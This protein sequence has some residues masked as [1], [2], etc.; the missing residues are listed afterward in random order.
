MAS[1]HFLLGLRKCN[2][3][4][5]RLTCACSHGAVYSHWVYLDSAHYQKTQRK[6]LLSASQSLQQ[7]L[8]SL[9]EH[10]A[11]GS[12][13][14]SRGVLYVSDD[15]YSFR[16]HQQC[17]ASPL[18]SYVLMLIPVLCKIKIALFSSSGLP[19]C[20]SPAG[21]APSSFLVF[22]IGASH[23]RFAHVLGRLIA[24]PRHRDLSGNQQC[25]I[26]A[27]VHSLPFLFT[28]KYFRLNQEPNSSRKLSK[29]TFISEDNW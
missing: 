26:I 29:K 18:Y 19:C 4:F 8:A 17:L 6:N 20:P 24:L 1:F 15:D 13:A 23:S 16:T 22:H 25:I 28:I 7:E 3:F 5:E 21:A 9:S 11:V 10:L 27:F 2:K 14:P 12:H